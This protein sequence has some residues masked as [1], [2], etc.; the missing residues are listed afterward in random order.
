MEGIEQN[1]E[2]EILRLQKQLTSMNP[3]SE[4]YKETLKAITALNTMRNDGRKLDAADFDAQEKRAYDNGR[5]DE[6]LELREA[7]V[8]ERK[9][10][11]LIR[12]IMG[13][14]ELI[15]P[16]CFYTVMYNRGL[17]FET[18]GTV[19]SQF[20]RNLLNRFNPFKR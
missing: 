18:E 13:G 8:A 16:L 4:K 15:V 7:E 5:A 3:D 14:V 11:R 1:F 10:D 20:F 6:E 9:K 12:I 2:T 19:T 17:A